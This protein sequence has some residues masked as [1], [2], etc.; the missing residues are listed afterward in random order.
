MNPADGPTGMWRSRKT[1][2]ACLGVFL[3]VLLGQY[4]YR[5]YTLGH[6][7]EFFINALKN[8]HIQERVSVQ[9][10]EYSV[11]RGTV[12]RADILVT[13]NK[14]LLPVLRLAYAMSMVRR[15]PL[16]ALEGS[17][18]TQ[19]RVAIAYL[20]EVQTK[21]V[22]TQKSSED[23][24]TVSALFPIQ[25]LQSLAAAEQARQNLLSSGT[26]EN[27]NLYNSALDKAMTSGVSNIQTYREA[28]LKA[29]PG[30]VRFSILS[31]IVSRTSE[32]AALADIKS[33][34][35]DIEREVQRR[36]RCLMVSTFFCSPEDIVLPKI[37]VPPAQANNT[38]PAIV[39]EILSI[40]KNAGEVFPE[41]IPL[42]ELSSNVCFP[43]S[44]NNYFAIRD[45][46]EDTGH[47]R[48]LM[49]VGDL[50]VYNIPDTKVHNN[51]DGFE[52]A[53][54]LGIHFFPIDG[55]QYYLCP[56]N[57]E[58]V[59]TSAALL[60][61]AEFAKQDTSPLTQ[62]V[63]AR[64]LRTDRITETDARAYL[65]SFQEKAGAT[66]SV[67][68]FNQFLSLLLMFRDTNASF[69]EVI[70]EVAANLNSR[71]K[72][73][74]AGGAVDLSPQFLFLTKSGFLSLFFG[75]TLSAGSGEHLFEDKSVESYMRMVSR[76]S[77][78]HPGLSNADVSSD[79]RLYLAMHIAPS[80]MEK[81]TP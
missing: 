65:Q 79:L 73:R 49:Y 2:L 37:S 55:A 35:A 29:V 44:K 59:G 23:R 48:K 15:S 69:E 58:I 77:E 32:L 10:K 22:D 25:F 38:V 68:Q 61:T 12:Y 81:T 52:F 56:Q 42:I 43:P 31:G 6:E 1:V 62:T 46:S 18:L 27:Y 5:A 63:R 14:E 33:G 76:W 67:E 17:D 11:S 24:A 39:H 51:H 20:N 47:L 53:R 30:P 50:F 40:R 80:E 36:T 78:P 60:K 21:L 7:E 9:G 70:N 16:L 57:K 41:H 74:A 8:Q 3:L 13:G 26:D 72:I 34:F 54:E 64:L 4:A 66:A 75:E 45:M 71:L 28:F 19:V